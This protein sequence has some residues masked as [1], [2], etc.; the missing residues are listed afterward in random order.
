[1]I[2]KANLCRYLNFDEIAGFEDFGRVIPVD[3]MPKLE[4]VLG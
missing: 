1:M 3:K 2:I 4:E